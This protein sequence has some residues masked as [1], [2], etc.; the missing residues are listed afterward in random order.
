MS[1]PRNPQTAA[2][3]ALIEA[4]ATELKLPTVKARFRAMAAEAL[5]EQQTPT[6]YLAALLEAEMNERAERRETL[7]DADDLFSGVLDD[8]HSGVVEPGPARKPNRPGAV[9]RSDPA[10]KNPFAP[11]RQVHRKHVIG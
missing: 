8:G 4:H 9:E 1:Q 6:A 5:R 7:C 2:M 11:L 10:N 3:E